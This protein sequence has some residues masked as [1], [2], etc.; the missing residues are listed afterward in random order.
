MVHETLLWRHQVRIAPGFLGCAFV[1]AEKGAV[2]LRLRAEA[3]AVGGG[4]EAFGFLKESGFGGCGGG[5]GGLS[6]G[7]EDEADREA[8]FGVEGEARAGTKGRRAA[9]VKCI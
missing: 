4:V 9:M 2:V 5:G 7:G 3:G 1:M 6:E 8:L